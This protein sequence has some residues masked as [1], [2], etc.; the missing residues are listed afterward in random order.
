MKIKNG[1]MLRHVAEQWVVVPIGERVV[2][3]SGILTLSETGAFLWKIL[4]NGATEDELIDKILAEYSVDEA[5]A[6]KDVLAFIDNVK[7]KGLLD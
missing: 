2:E 4:E 1:F 5:T 7:Q 3:V 6:R